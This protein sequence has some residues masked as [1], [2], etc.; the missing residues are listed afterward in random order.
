MLTSWTEL[1]SKR[2]SETAATAFCSKAVVSQSFA[3]WACYTFEVRKSRTLSKGASLPRRLLRATAESFIAAVQFAA[4]Q[5]QH[6]LY[7]ELQRML[8]Q[9]NEKMKASQDKI[10]AVRWRD[11][12]VLKHLTRMSKRHQAKQNLS[13]RKILLRVE[14]KQARG[15]VLDVASGKNF[16]EEGKSASRESLE[17]WMSTC[18]TAAP[19]PSGT[20]P[21]PR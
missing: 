2:R 21:H 19:S 8:K 15:A 9:H 16:G 14:M 3:A 10:D 7:R 12:P 5:D 4:A 1:A 18:S 20:P 6:E 17:S 13:V 11:R